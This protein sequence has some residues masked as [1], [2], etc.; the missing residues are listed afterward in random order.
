MTSTQIPDPAFHKWPASTSPDYVTARRSLLEKE[1][2][3]IN[4]IEEIAAQR[5]ALP[6]GP[7]LPTYTF[8][9][10]P[11]DIN[12]T[13]PGHQVTLAEVAKG[14]GK[15]GHKTLVIYHMMMDKDD[16]KA[17]AGCSMFVDGLNGVAKHLAQRFNLAIV[18]KAPLPAIREYARKRGW[19][20]LRFLSSS[21][22]DFNKDIGME[23]PPWMKDMGQGPGLSVFVYE[24]ADDEKE[25]GKVRFW[26]QT[27]PHLAKIGNND[28]I[29]GMDL[30]T[31]VWQLF[32]ITPEGRGNWDPGHDYVE[33]WNTAKS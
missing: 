1:Y 31:P 32:D 18:A 2:A 27:T 24:E 30:L 28:V 12:S 9:E 29:R 22:S 17:C 4:Q 33:E 3:L 26:Y 8:E 10:G 6:P 23:N 16:V 15:A 21:D 5:R 14:D 11:K 19:N 13:S 7:V 20:D 25:E